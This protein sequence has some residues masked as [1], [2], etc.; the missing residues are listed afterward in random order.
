MGHNM[1]AQGQRALGMAN[2]DCAMPATDFAMLAEALGAR[3]IV[4]RH[5]A[6]LMPTLISALRTSRPVVVDVRID[7]EPL[8]PTDDRFA[9]LRG[10]EAR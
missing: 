5:A 4:V 7:P 10:Q 1:C 6:E 8:A 3:G 9:G 2:V